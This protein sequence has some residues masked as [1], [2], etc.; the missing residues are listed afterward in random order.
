MVNDGP[1]GYDCDYKYEHFFHL[2]FANITKWGAKVWTY[3]DEQEG[4]DHDNEVGHEASSRPIDLCRS[5]S[6]GSRAA[7]EQ[8]H[9]MMFVEHHLRGAAL[10]DT[11]RQLKKRGWRT[12]VCPAEPT[13][14]GGTHGGAVALIKANL[15]HRPLVEGA[16]R[17][18]GTQWTGM[19]VRF[20]GRDLLLLTAYLWH[21]IGFT[22]ENLKILR[23]LAEV[24][25]IHK[26]EYFI[27]ADWNIPVV[28]M[29]ASALASADQGHS[30]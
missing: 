1:A 20:A 22:G 21:S 8:P 16:A 6:G 28:D 5:S 29:E 14:K 23:Q 18:Q 26:V 10:N 19:M 12:E 7:H 11:R 27:A 30:R 4:K 24:V 13:A 15:A 9:M 25:G 3:L 17:I 2:K